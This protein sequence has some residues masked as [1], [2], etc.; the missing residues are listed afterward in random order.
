M[1]DTAARE[2]R[3]W[4]D[5]VVILTNL[6]LVGLAAWNA[7]ASSGA[8]RALLVLAAL[9]LLVFGSDAFRE[10]AVAV[11]VTILLPALL[12][13]GSAPFFGPMPRHAAGVGSGTDA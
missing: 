5:I 10:Q 11:W 8:G 7:P 1:A 3:R 2:R 13:L 4:A 6:M 12:L 9:L